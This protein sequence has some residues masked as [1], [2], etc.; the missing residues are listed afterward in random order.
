MDKHLAEM[1]LVVSTS[2]TLIVRWYSSRSWD[3]GPWNC[4]RKVWITHDVELPRS[5][6]LCRCNNCPIVKINTPIEEKKLEHSN[7]ILKQLQL[8]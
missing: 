6:V 2:A 4:C 1:L 7:N 8:F 5:F 3:V